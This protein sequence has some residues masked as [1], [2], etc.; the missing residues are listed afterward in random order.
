LTT[1]AKAGALDGTS[2]GYYERKFWVVQTRLALF[3]SLSSAN[4]AH[5]TPPYIFLL[6]S[7]S[8]PQNW[9]GMNPF[10]HASTGIGSLLVGHQFDIEMSDPEVR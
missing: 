1:A 3:F 7:A 9:V 2:S 5:S 6:G 10:I 8:N 4:A